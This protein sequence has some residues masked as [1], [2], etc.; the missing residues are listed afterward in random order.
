[1]APLRV[2]IIDDSEDDREAFRRMLTHGL[3]AAYD[4]V[5]AAAGGQLNPTQ[6]ASLLS[7]MGALAQIVED[8]ELLGRNEALERKHG[9]GA[10][11]TTTFGP[12]SHES[13]IAAA[14][15]TAASWSMRPACPWFASRL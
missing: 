12:L 6:A 8:D 7:A 4:V 15:S 2:L 3:P 10:R 9:L 11:E 1:M 13:S 14:R 5:E